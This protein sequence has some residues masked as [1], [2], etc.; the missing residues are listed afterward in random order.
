MAKVHIYLNFNGQCEEAFEFY[1]KI[2]K[3]EN[4]GV[5]R[6]KD[7]PEDPNYPISDED[8][9]K[10]MHTAISINPHTML[11]GSDCLESF[12][13]KATSGTNTY[14][15]LDTDTAEEAKELYAALTE[16][17]GNIEMELA[18]QFWAELYASFED[19]YGI[20]WMIHYEGNKKM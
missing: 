16:N 5:Y 19:K 6:M 15:M 12:G 20:R 2:F 3:T 7:M 9:N 11:M 13:Q 10:V 14:V 8:K 18:E 1:A 4:T 17:A